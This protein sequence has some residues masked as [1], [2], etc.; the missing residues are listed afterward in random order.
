MTSPDECESRY[1]EGLWCL[2]ALRDDIAPEGSNSLAGDQNMVDYGRRRSF[3]QR[4]GLLKSF[5]EIIRTKLRL[6]RCR[7]RMKMDDLAR[8][9]D[10]R[11]DHN[12]DD[13]QRFPP[14]W[15]IGVV[16]A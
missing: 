3:T 13:V 12:L 10:A 5:P 7:T 8:V 15:E 16:G 14:P 9:R 4:E 2:Y 11:A 6:H 1:E